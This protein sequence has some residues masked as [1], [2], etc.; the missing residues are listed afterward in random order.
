MSR[1]TNDT[2]HIIS[3]RNEEEIST[4]TFGN[5]TAHDLKSVLS[6]DKICLPEHSV[7]VFLSPLTMKNRWEGE[8]LPE[9]DIQ[10]GDVAFLPAD[11]EIATV[12]ASASTDATMVTFPDAYFRAA[13]MGDI[14]YDDIVLRHAYL[15]ASSGTG[16]VATAV[17]NLAAAGKRCFPPILIE[18]LGIS[19]AVALASALNEKVRAVVRSKGATLS[20]DRKRRV[21][22]F[23]E[24]NMHRPI[25][26]TEIASVA[27][28]S[29]FHFS[30][31][32]KRTLGVSPVRYLWERRVDAAKKL[33]M[34]GGESLAQVAL[35]CG[36]SSQS[37]FTTKFRMVTGHTPT[38]FQRAVKGLAN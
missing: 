26:L 2:E 6:V 7:Y 32:F 35:I 30:R 37:H 28:M 5:I 8:I 15:P 16:A 22:E 23:I 34:A 4:H 31:S 14:N 13:C 9:Q 33:I 27:A 10:A 38:E 3:V 29:P 25:S 36:F 21:V 19:L 12:S 18:S 24:D 17:R 1:C 11:S 20:P